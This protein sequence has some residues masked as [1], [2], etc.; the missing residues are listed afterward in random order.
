MTP[1]R[2]SGTLSSATEVVD[3]GGSAGVAA[4]AGGLRGGAGEMVDRCGLMLEGDEAGDVRGVTG[5]GQFARRL[6][7]G[8]GRKF[9]KSFGAATAAVPRDAVV[10]AAG[11]SGAGVWLPA[12]NFGLWVP[13]LEAVGA[14]WNPSR[15]CRTA[16]ATW[17]R[18]AF[19]LWN[20][21]SRFV[22]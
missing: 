1:T 21:T 5:D 12:R 10:C 9:G 15:L 4:V 20:F 16:A 2:P 22:G 14:E 13:D 17:A 11:A 3:A 19:S 18:T 8:G 6:S 7:G